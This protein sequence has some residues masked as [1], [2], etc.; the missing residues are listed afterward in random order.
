[1]FE[2][3]SNLLEGVSAVSATDVW[4]V[5]YSDNSFNGEARTLIL[6][7]NGTAWSKS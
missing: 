5:G 6:H 4:A 3:A 1:V 2:P 7:W